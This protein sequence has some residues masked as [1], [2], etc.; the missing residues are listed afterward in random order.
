MKTHFPDKLEISPVFGDSWKYRVLLSKF[1]YYL[2][3]SSQPIT[4][5]PGF[6]TDYA[7]IPKYLW[8][9]I[10]SW[11]PH[12]PAAIVH[13]YL[14]AQAHKLKVPNPS[15][16]TQLITNNRK[17]SDKIFLIAMKQLGTPFFKRRLMYRAVRIFGSLYYNKR[18]EKE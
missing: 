3:P 10:P 18:K 4:I 13:D 9:L 15:N 11:G 2:T 6:I 7:S 14:Y 8:S 5:P 12:G 16:P 17:I 1:N